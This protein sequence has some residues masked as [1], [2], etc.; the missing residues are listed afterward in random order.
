MFADSKPRGLG[1]NG[2]EL[3]TDIFWCI[4]LK[5]EAVYLRETPERKIKITDLA[6]ILGFAVV[7]SNAL[8]AC[9]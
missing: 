6:L 3:A 9:K 7:V 8:K 4:R 2:L 5:I 1:C